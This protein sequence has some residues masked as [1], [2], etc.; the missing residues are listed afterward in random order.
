VFVVVIAVRRVQVPVVQI[1]HMVPVRHGHV[2]TI[3]SVHVVVLG[4]L[5]ATFHVAGIPMVVVLVV[6]MTIGAVHMGMVGV[7]PVLHDPSMSFVAP[8]GSSLSS[9]VVSNGAWIA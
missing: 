7:G 6:Q 8:S 1:I 2:S 3:R 4:V 5:D 9:D